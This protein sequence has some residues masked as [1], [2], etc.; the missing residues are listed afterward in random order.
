MSKKNE[1]AVNQ[2]AEQALEKTPAQIEVLELDDAM[3]DIV[4]GGGSKLPSNA[5]NFICTN[6]GRC[7]SDAQ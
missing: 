3:L 6:N 5:S 2:S 4:S 1:Q 7:S